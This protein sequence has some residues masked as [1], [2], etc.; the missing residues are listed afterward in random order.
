MI[1]RHR[2]LVLS[3]ALVAGAGLL[4]FTR[5]APQVV[6][7]QYRVELGMGIDIAAQPEEREAQRRGIEATINQIA[8]EGFELL[9]VVP[10]GAVFRKP[11]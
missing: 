3:L 5:P 8:S 11:R 2:S 4:A 7:W 6:A 9:Q 10:G 1:R